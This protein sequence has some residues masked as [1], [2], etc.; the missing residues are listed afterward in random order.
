MFDFMLLRHDNFTDWP[1]DPEN[2]IR[3]TNDFFYRQKIDPGKAAYTRG[4]QIIRP[5][6]PKSELSWKEVGLGVKERSML[7][8]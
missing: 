1:Q 3:E 2:V 5:S 8:L 4:V 6:R 7:S